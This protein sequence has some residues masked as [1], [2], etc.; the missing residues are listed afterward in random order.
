LTCFGDCK[1]YNYL[2][3][4]IRPTCSERTVEL[5]AHPLIVLKL[6]RSGSEWITSLLASHPSIRT[7]AHELLHAP[8]NTLGQAR[9]MTS[10]FPAYDAM[11]SALACRR[12]ENRTAAWLQKLGPSPPPGTRVCLEQRVTLPPFEETARCEMYCQ[13]A[14]CFNLNPYRLF[15]SGAKCT[16]FYKQRW[17][18]GGLSSGRSYA[19]F[20]RFA[21]DSGA[22]IL[23]LTR[24]DTFAS[25]V[26]TYKAE[27]ATRKKPCATVRNYY[28]KTHDVT[29][30]YAT[31]RLQAN[32]SRMVEIWRETEFR[33]RQIDGLRKTLAANGVPVS[34]LTYEEVVKHGGNLPKWLW[35]FLQLR[36]TVA[37]ASRVHATTIISCW[38]SAFLNAQEVYDAFVGAMTVLQQERLKCTTNMMNS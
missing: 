30:C 11:L 16:G 4:P 32:V 27:W 15:E 24:Q 31:L 12:F 21:L 10:S 23:I 9:W 5:L 1:Q 38:R 37:T 22:R 33:H 17:D 13:R 34:L 29:T 18:A 7:C 25:T 8:Q 2:R 14:A 35:D 19:L 36:Q 6:A 20:E 26:S 3:P 28:R